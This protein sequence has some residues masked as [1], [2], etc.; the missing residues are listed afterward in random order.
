MRILKNAIAVALPEA[1]FLQSTS[2]EGQTD[3]DISEMGQR[4]S[5][6][7]LQYVRENCPGN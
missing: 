6:E 2:N 5:N 7:V 3:G 1:I 4:L